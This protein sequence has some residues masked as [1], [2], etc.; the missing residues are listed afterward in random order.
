MWP[1]ARPPSRWGAPASPR[2]SRTPSRSSSARARASCRARSST[3]PVAPGP[4]VVTTAGLREMEVVDPLTGQAFP[5]WVLYPSTVAERAVRL[6]RYPA[7]LAPDAP[8]ADGRFPLVVVSHGTGSSPFLH[9]VLA[10]HL[11]RRGFVVALP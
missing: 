9:R 11:A 3:S 1:P 10:A 4:E 2:T 8:P 7:S 6:G 5:V